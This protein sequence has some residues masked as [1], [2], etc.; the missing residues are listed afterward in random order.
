MRYAVDHIGLLVTMQGPDGPR[1]G[2]AMGHI[3]AIQSA[4][5]IVADGKIEAAGPRDVLNLSGLET[6][7][8]GGRLVTPGLIDSHTH[9]VFGGERAHEFGARC[10]GA[11]YEQIAASGGGIRSTVAKTCAASFEEL[12]E[13]GK[14][15]LRWMLASGTTALEAKSG[16]GDSIES[17][18]TLLRAIAELQAS[19][20][21]SI[22]STFLGAH[23]LPQEF[24]G[25]KQE[26]FDQLEAEAFPAIAEQKLASACDMFVERGYFNDG[27]AARWATMAAAF[28]LGLRLHVDQLNNNH[29]ARLAVSLGATSA[30]HLEQT[31]DDGI[32][33]LAASRT[34][35]GL[36]P[37]S[38]FALCKS[39][40]PN[41]RRMIDAGV[42]V[43]LATDFNPGS[44]PTPSLPFAMSLACTQ[45]AMSP[46]E[47]LSAC[48]VNAAHSLGWGQRKGQLAAGF[49]ADFVLWD[50]NHWQ[51]IPYW[52]AAPAVHSVYVVGRLMSP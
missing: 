37:A 33:A 24:Q 47:C 41:A 29:G 51:E 46:A 17:E 48:T 31:D 40:Y 1:I 2:P 49:D 4:A 42:R 26:F 18:L 8:A 16:Y 34:F 39:K 44:S 28:G 5:M 20:G 15:N 38:V 3:S 43:T 10:Q 19:S 45:M 13:T 30:D 14:R 35:A 7:D 52:I 21:V 36:L 6:I 11:T 50:L 32:R 9:L 23:S 12:V 25:R 27:D 22:S